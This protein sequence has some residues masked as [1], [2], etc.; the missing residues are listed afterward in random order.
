LTRLNDVQVPKN[1]IDPWLRSEEREKEKK[2]EN[3]EWESENP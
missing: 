2:A 3:R 1:L